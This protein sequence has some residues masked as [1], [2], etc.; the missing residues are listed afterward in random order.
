MVNIYY[1]IFVLYE[2]LRMCLY[3]FFH[4]KKYISNLKKY[5]PCAFFED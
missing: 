1:N 2:F 4:K 5:H 3:H